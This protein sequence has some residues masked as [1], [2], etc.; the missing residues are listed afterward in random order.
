MMGNK[1]EID[2]LK[3]ILPSGASGLGHIYQ[4]NWYQGQIVKQKDEWQVYLN[5]HS[6]LTAEDIAAIKKSLEN[7]M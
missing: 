6:K 4:G 7:N 3:I 5:S 2:S 1:I